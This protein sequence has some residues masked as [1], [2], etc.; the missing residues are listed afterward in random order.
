MAGPLGR[1]SEILGSYPRSQCSFEHMLAASMASPAGSAGT[2]MRWAWRAAISHS[3]SNSLRMFGGRSTPVATIRRRCGWADKMLAMFSVAWVELDTFQM[4]RR[5]L[6]ARAGS[7]AAP[8]SQQAGVQ[9]HGRVRRSA[10]EHAHRGF[11]VGCPGQLRARPFTDTTSCRV[12]GRR[13]HPWPWQT[14]AAWR[15]C[16]AASFIRWAG[17][18]MT[19]HPPRREARPLGPPRLS[20][21]ARSASSRAPVSPFAVCRPPVPTEA[22]SNKWTR[23]IFA[24]DASPSI[25]ISSMY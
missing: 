20:R 1:A 6:Q 21:G 3:L 11:L 12:G 10:S 9:K 13:W 15:R 23:W 24:G 8:F 25:A 2:C 16:S 18:G 7:G 17:Q 14:G 19:T 4:A 22:T 5:T